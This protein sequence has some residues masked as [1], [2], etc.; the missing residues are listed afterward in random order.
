MLNSNQEMFF[1]GRISPSKKHLTQCA[2]DSHTKVSLLYQL[3]IM[4]C[5]AV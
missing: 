5:K 2:C 1:R 3:L 4:P